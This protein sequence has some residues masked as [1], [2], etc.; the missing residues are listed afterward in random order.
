MKINALK[1]IVKEDLIKQGE[2]PAW[3]D[4]FLQSI[5]DFISQ[6]GAAVQGRLSFADNFDCKIH[7]QKF[8]SGVAVN[9]NPQTQRR[10]VGVIPLYWGGKSKTGFAWDYSTNN[11]V[12]VT[13]TFS[14]GG[15]AN[16]RVLI[17]LG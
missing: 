7:S 14:G 10:P 1:R 2:V 13:F 12:S 15:D 3:M 11:Q 16:C 5:N 4:P 17:L 8:T 6:V 9:V